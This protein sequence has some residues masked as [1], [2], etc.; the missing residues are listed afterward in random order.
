[1]SRAKDVL[2]IALT[3]NNL[4]DILSEDRDVFGPIYAEVVDFISN[5]YAQYS[6]APSATMVNKHFKDNDLVSEKKGKL[7]YE[8]DALRSEFVK[9]E[10]ESMMVKISRNLDKRSSDDILAQMIQ[11]ASALQRLTSGAKDIDITDVDLAVETFRR[12]REEIEEHGGGIMSGIEAWDH[13]IPMGMQPGNSITLMGYSGKGKSFIADLVAVNAYLQGKTVMI[14]S[15]EMSADEQRAR[16]MGILGKGRYLINELAVG[17]VNDDEFTSW[18]MQNLNTGGKIIVVEQE[19]HKS[20]TPASLQA[21]IDKHR[22]DMVVFDY[23]QLMED[24]GRT[25]EITPRMMNL[26]REIKQLAT[27]NKIVCV[28]ITAV[29]DDETKKRDAPPRMSQIAWSKAVEYDSDLVIA[30]HRYDDTDFMELVA[31]KVR[32]SA[33]FAMRYTVDLS[34]GVFNPI[35]DSEYA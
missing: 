17:N 28:S 22:P 24:N 21:K 33:F 23:L 16:M 1:M 10:I 32:R 15:W 31:R 25:K 19:G 7:Q 18:G 2:S 13:A 9:G 34:R 8:I 4:S 20:M 27:S 5:Y 6:E 30:V 26:S 35:M 29:T 14:G 12:K 11:K 3:E